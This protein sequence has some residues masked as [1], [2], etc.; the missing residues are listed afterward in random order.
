MV[1]SVFVSVH[2]AKAQLAMLTNMTMIVNLL[3]LLTGPEI[4]DTP[5]QSQA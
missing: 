4:R 1:T 5:S 2:G 3:P